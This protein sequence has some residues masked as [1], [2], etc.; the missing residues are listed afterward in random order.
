[1]KGC[2][3]NLNHLFVYHRPDILAV[4]KNLADMEAYGF[5][6]VSYQDIGWMAGEEMFQ[7]P[8][9]DGHCRTPDDRAAMPVELGHDLDRVSLML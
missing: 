6:N 7:K 9:L 3:R 1:L 8:V 2:G 4:T 5:A